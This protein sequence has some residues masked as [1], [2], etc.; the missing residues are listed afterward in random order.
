MTGVPPGLI[1]SI[2][3]RGCT[4]GQRSDG[5]LAGYVLGEPWSLGPLW[6]KPMLQGAVC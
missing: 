4:V 3:S 2:V 5:E 6:L 1:L